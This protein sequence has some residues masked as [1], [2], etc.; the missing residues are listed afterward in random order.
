MTDWLR[1]HWLVEE[2]RHGT[3]LKRY[4]NAVWPEF[5]WGQVYRKFY[6]EYSL[7]GCAKQ[8]G[9][10]HALEMV[11]RC[12]VE[13]GT[14]C[15]Y[16]LLYRLTEEPVLR[17]LMAR[18]KNDEIYHYKNFFDCYLRYQ[19]DEQPPARVV[20]KT[21]CK[22]ISEIDGE[23]AFITFKHVFEQ[24]VPDRPLLLTT[25]DYSVTT[26]WVSRSAIFRTTWLHR[27]FCDR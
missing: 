12:L 24:C 11:S 8:L 20:L 18:M 22:R 9:P 23:D 26:S 7:C 2:L 17:V 27:C 3:A 16:T 25:N 1:D 6:A 15:L 10:T 4:I 5:D 14:S 13:T 19:H 21:L